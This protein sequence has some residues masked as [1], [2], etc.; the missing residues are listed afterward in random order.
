MASKPVSDS[1]KRAARAVEAEFDRNSDGDDRATNALISQINHN[2]KAAGAILKQ[3]RRDDDAK[4]DNVVASIGLTSADRLLSGTGAFD[5][6][7]SDCLTPKILRHISANPPGD[8]PGEKAV[9]QLSAHYLL[10]HYWNIAGRSDDSPANA[11][12]TDHHTPILAS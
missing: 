6:R 11:D 9:N 12:G 7:V 8:S 3:L 5:P 1:P 10:K 2:P 4:N